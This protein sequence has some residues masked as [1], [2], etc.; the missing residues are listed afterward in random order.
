MKQKIVYL[1]HKRTLYFMVYNNLVE[2]HFLDNPIRG[3]QASVHVNHE[4]PLA[5]FPMTSRLEQWIKEK[6]S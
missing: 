5:N 6:K 3:V 1:F 4:A 2:T